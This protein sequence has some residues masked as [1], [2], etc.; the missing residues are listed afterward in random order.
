MTPT[1]IAKRVSSLAPEG[2]YAVLAKA[3]ALEKTGKSV[4]HLEI[5][6]PDFATPP[7]ICYAAIDAI[8]HGDTRYTDPLGVPLLREAIAAYLT[9]TRA[10]SFDGGE[11]AVTPSAKT[12]LFV[13]F[14]LLVNPGDEVIF[15]DPGFP[16]YEALTRL[17]GAVPRPVPLVEHQQ[18][19]FDVPSLKKAFSSRTKLIILNSPG[20][21]TG[22]VL[23][24]RDLQAISRIV[25]NSRAWVLSDEIYSQITY[26]GEEA[27]SIST[28]P[29]MRDRTIIVDGFSKTFAMTGWRLGFLRVP[30]WCMSEVSTIL[31]HTVGCT[32]TFTQRAGIAALASGGRF[33]RSMLRAFSRRRDYVVVRL[34][35]MRGVSCVV[36]QGAFYAFPNIQKTGKSSAELADFLLSEAGVAVLPGSS[37]GSHGEGYVRLSYAASLP[38]LGEGL[39]RM[40]KALETI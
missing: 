28:I 40:A 4:I 34:R 24:K 32:A 8:T 13:A 37:F 23:G 10:V 26:D 20:N 12:A 39:A 33:V 35:T 16:A 7:D 18:F 14:A 1:L 36:P 19:S 6:Q 11:I 31:T 9:K 15:P 21:P 25:D 3:Q 27:P 17:F 30:P 38:V 2:A 22:G 29:A 5:G